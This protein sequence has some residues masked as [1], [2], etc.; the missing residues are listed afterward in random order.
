MAQIKI[1]QSETYPTDIHKVR[2][3]IL[4]FSYGTKKEIIEE[5]IHK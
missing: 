1:F 5:K 2:S 4:D 3:E